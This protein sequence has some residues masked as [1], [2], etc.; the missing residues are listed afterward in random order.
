MNRA[1]HKVARR[2]PAG[3]TLIEVLIAVVVIAIGLLGL[4]GLQS[5]VI[6]N[7][8]VSSMRSI[9]SIH[10]ENMAEM[11][12]ANIAGVNGNFYAQ[13]A[14]AGSI[15]YATIK[16]APPPATPNVDCRTKFGSSTRCLAGQQALADTF[17]W[18]QAVQRDL[19]GGTGR[20]VCS[21]RDTTDA[22]PCS[23]GSSH[24]IT[25]SWQEKDVESRASLTKSFATVFQP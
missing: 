23:N 1:G 21:D 25:I 14:D 5:T 4:A 13:G 20:V 11:M 7:G 6:A 8:H 22:D 2:L 16:P 17:F 12:R 19:P 18:I 15:N 10:I 24:T 9:A 3:F